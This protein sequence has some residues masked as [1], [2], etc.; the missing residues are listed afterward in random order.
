MFRVR[1]K[2]LFVLFTLWRRLPPTYRRLALTLVRRHGRRGLI[3][4]SLFA[5]R[6]AAAQL[7]RRRR[8]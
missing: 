7:K 1:L 4:I 3:V 2:A 8:V 5:R 6:Y